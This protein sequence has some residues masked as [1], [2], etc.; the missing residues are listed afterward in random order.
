V[1]VGK[2][3]SESI[4]LDDKTNS[5]R[6]STARRPPA[7]PRAHEGHECPAER[8]RRHPYDSWPASASVSDRAAM[9]TPH[10]HKWPP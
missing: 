6:P 5:A 2:S 1:V 3:G 4:Q 7:R 10:W 9:V 8:R